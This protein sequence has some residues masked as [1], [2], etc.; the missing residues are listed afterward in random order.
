MIARENRQKGKN[1]KMAKVKVKETWRIPK[2]KRNHFKTNQDNKKQINKRITQEE[3]TMFR[4]S[5]TNEIT[6]KGMTNTCLTTISSTI[7]TIKTEI[8]K[9]KNTKKVQTYNCGENTQWVKMKDIF[10]CS[11]CGMNRNRSFI[12]DKDDGETIGD[13]YGEGIHEN[14]SGNIVSYCYTCKL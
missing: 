5:K 3:K 11:N 10:R 4:Y 14:C 6:S 2:P 12:H 8:T 7:T 9:D 1:T 13:Y